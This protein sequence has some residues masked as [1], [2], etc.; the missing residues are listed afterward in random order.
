MMAQEGTVHAALDLASPTGW[1]GAMPTR[2]PD[3]DG[4]RSRTPRPRS[5]H[6]RPARLA[7]PRGLSLRARQVL[8]LVEQ[9]RAE[10]RT[11]SDPMQA[12]SVRE[13]LDGRL[14]ALAERMAANRF[15][16]RDELVA[17]ALAGWFAS[18]ARA[19]LVRA[20]LR[21]NGIDVTG[22]HLKL[23]RKVPLHRRR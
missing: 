14:S 12:Y 8:A 3:P 21:A 11:A 18:G 2:T 7:G 16:G 5:K 9:A 23:R 17:L 4:R 15:E 1:D 6:T 13:R 19:T 20:V 22:R 10:E